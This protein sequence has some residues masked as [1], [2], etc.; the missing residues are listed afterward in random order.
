VALVLGAEDKGLSIPVKRRCDA[1][2]RIPF[3]GGLR[4]L[5]VAVAGA[6][7]MYTCT[8]GLK[9]TRNLRTDFERPP[10]PPRRS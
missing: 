1:L 4:S 2:V 5:N 8:Y 7:A 10:G 3:G 9:A 6:I